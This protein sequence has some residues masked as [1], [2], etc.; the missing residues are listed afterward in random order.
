MSLLFQPINPT[1]LLY[2]TLP[3][4]LHLA[5]LLRLLHST[6][7]QIPNSLPHTVTTSSNAPNALNTNTHHMV[8]RAKADISKPFTRMNYH[9][10]TTSLIPRSYLH[11]LRDPHWH[12]A[13][14]D[15]YNALISNGTWALVP[16]P[17]NVNVVRSM[18]L[19]RHKYNAN[20]SLSSL[21]VKSATIRT[22]LSLVVTPDWP[23][24][25]LDVK[26]AFLYGQLS[27]IVYMHQPPGFFDSTHP[28]YVCHLHRLLYG[29]KQAPRGSDIAYLLLYVD[30]IVLTALSTVLLQ[31]VITLLHGE[32]SMIDLGSLN[33]F[34]GISAQRSK[35]GLF[36]V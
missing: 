14:V 13:M 29:L 26:N 27:E 36:F 23:I 30:E 10:T 8:T 12:K 22:V 3:S 33:Y 24:H 19:F 18:W 20:G 4:P 5:Q 2:L 31:L 34:L 16:R 35:S 32:F 21:V 25:R 17:S 11:A 9:A 7:Q 1:H 28:N 15:E 6:Q